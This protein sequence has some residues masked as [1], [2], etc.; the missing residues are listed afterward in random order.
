[1][2]QPV[3][4]QF[5]VFASASSCPI[6]YPLVTS[7]LSST[8]A[9]SCA[10]AQCARKRCAALRAGAAALWRV[11]APS[12]RQQVWQPSTV[13]LDPRWRNPGKSCCNS[14]APDFEYDIISIMICTSY[15]YHIRLGY[16]GVFDR[17]SESES[18][19]ESPISKFCT[20]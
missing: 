15:Q 2:R 19:I 1:M 13:A 16:P 17:D 4:E 11:S 9:C 18:D 10:D 14:A 12:T 3:R 7:P 6:I 5:A 20:S 8:D